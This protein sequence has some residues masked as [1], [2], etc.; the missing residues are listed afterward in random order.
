VVVLR[1]PAGA[2]AVVALI[3]SGCSGGSDA[4]DAGGGRPIDAAAS[5]DAF[6]PL[7]ADFQLLSE[8]GLY[9][10][11]ASRTL[12]DG[13]LP[14]APEFPL[15]SDGADKQR[16]VWLPPGE[17]IDTSDMDDWKFPPGTRLWK[18]FSS[19]ELGLV[20]T[21]LVMRLGPEPHQVFMTSFVWN[22]DETDAVRAATAA[23]LPID[24][25]TLCPDGY[26]TALD[27]E[28]AANCHFVPPEA[29]CVTCHAGQAH[30]VL[31]FQ[32]VQL[33][34]ASPGLDL[35]ELVERDLVSDPPPAGEGYPVPGSGAARDAL[36][37]L[38]ANCGHCHNRALVRPDTCFGLTSFEA[39]VYTADETVEETAV[40][41]TGVN[42]P[43]LF[44]ATAGDGN[45][46][47]I[48]C[49]ITP[50]D[51]DASAVVARMNKR[52]GWIRPHGQMPPEYTTRI[53]EAGVAAVRAWVAALAEPAAS[54]CAPPR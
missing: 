54:L 50:G 49:R 39:R 4:A 5:P 14:F 10:D 12:A 9:A 19:P 30:G 31:G 20:E 53:D 15:W 7:A 11:L 38:H 18:T 44:W 40:Y 52:D 48:P 45:V 6:E 13:V 16:Y 2:L 1:R 41:Q 35:A 8:T 34:F 24:G 46:D 17:R 26:P 42:Q 3:A 27:A 22:D 25:V 51:P 21:R 43:L 28:A 33:S 47:G 36:G 23:A 29:D 37:Y 32:A